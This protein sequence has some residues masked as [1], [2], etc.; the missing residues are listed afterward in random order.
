MFF[1]DAFHSKIPSLKLYNIE[2]LIFSEKK[3]K[4]GNAL[5]NYGHSNLYHNTIIKYHSTLSYLPFQP[6][7]NSIFLQIQPEIQ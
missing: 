1:Y 2:I 6:D 3:I 4:K 5:Q 7:K